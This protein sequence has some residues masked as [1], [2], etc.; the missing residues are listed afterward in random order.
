MVG[1]AG[2]QLLIRSDSLDFMNYKKR[3]I[4]E[5]QIGKSTKSINQ[6]FEVEIWILESLNIQT[7]WSRAGRNT[8]ANNLIHALL[9]SNWLCWCNFQTDLI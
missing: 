4:A 6:R 2:K 5:I 3:E 1:L 8:M 7:G 9:S